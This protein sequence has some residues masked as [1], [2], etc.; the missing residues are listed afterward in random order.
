MKYKSLW[1]IA[2]SWDPVGIAGNI[3]A[4]NLWCVFLCVCFNVTA[5]PLWKQLNP[6]SSLLKSW[7]LYFESIY[8]FGLHIR[9][10]V[11]ELFGSFLVQWR[12][13][14]SIHTVLCFSEKPSQPV[15]LEQK[16]NGLCRPEVRLLCTNIGL[17]WKVW[18]GS[19]VH[20]LITTLTHKR[21]FIPITVHRLFVFSES[22][23]FETIRVTVTADNVT[24]L[25]KLCKCAVCCF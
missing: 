20:I 5:V 6:I 16:T 9:T 22:W 24:K 13:S 3:A 23:Q 11:K 15:R 25:S 7:W 1:A 21:Q 12:N 8:T 2:W 19:A 4:L 14:H 10:Q 18:I 17:V